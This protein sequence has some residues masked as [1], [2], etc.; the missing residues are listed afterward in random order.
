[1]APQQANQGRAVGGASARSA[2]PAQVQG[3]SGLD[4]GEVGLSPLGLVADIGGTNCRLALARFGSRDIHAPASY[5]VAEY[6]DL[7][8][9]IR[10]YLA[11]DPSRPAL[12]WAV[13]AVAGPIENDVVNL[14]NFSWRIAASDIS[15]EFGIAHVRL[16]ND[17]GALARSTPMLAGD[18]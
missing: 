8:D 7:R 1:M 3:A 5:A 10:A 11:R 17:F 9:A 4:S 16:V 14:T 13:I 15:A 12:T 18:D 6:P 2:G